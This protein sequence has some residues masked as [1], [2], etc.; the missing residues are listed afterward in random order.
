MNNYKNVIVCNCALG[1][2]VG[3]QTLNIN[4][5]NHGGNS[6]IPFDAYASGP[7]SFSKEEISSRYSNKELFEQVSVETLDTI[8]Q[9][10]AIKEVSIMKI[11]VEGF[12]LEALRGA[13]EALTRG[14]VKN[15][16]CEVNN[17]KTRQEV[18]NIFIKNGY[19]PYRL[20]FGGTPIS[21]PENENLAYVH[22][23]ILFS[24]I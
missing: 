1:A 11:D 6:L 7:V 23:N 20:S 5:L 8:F 2:E 10:Y 22:D 24:R 18:F 19:A 12:E 16:V 9:K 21:I 4:P 17:N 15:I 13:K 14:V 3:R